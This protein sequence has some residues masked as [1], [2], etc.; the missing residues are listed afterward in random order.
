MKSSKH[1]ESKGPNSLH[2]FE[3]I[4]EANSA[5]LKV[6][7]MHA[8]ISRYER[9]NISLQNDYNIRGQIDLRHHPGLAFK[10]ADMAIIMAINMLK[11]NW[12][13][14]NDYFNFLDLAVLIVN[15][16]SFQ[17]EINTK[18]LLNDF[19]N[20]LTARFDLEL[21]KYN[22]M[23][24]MAVSLE[25]ERL[26]HK[27]QSK[28]IKTNIESLRLSLK[29]IID[30]L[31]ISTAHYQ[32][33]F[34]KAK[35][36]YSVCN[37]VAY[38]ATE[39][40]EVLQEINNQYRVE[41]NFLFEECLIGGVNI[42]KKMQAAAAGEL[43]EY[44]QKFIF[45]DKLISHTKKSNT[46]I[47]PGIYF[48]D[49]PVVRKRQPGPFYY[50][51]TDMAEVNL[52]DV[53]ELN[54]RICQLNNVQEAAG[55]ILNNYDILRSYTL[56]VSCLVS[57]LLPKS[58]SLL[59]NLFHRYNSCPSP[60][61]AAI[62]DKKLNQ[63]EN[64]QLFRNLAKTR[65]YGCSKLNISIYDEGGRREAEYFMSPL[66]HAVEYAPPEVVRI[67]LENN[68][69][70][71]PVD[72][73]K[74]PLHRAMIRGDLAIVKLLLHFGARPNMVTD[75]QRLTPLHD[76]S[77]AECAR[78]LIETVAEQSV[79]NPNLNLSAII[80]AQDC[81]GNTPLLSV[82]QRRVIFHESVA[83]SLERSLV[84]AQQRQALIQVYIDHN[85][86]I[87]VVNKFGH[88]ALHYLLMLKGKERSSQVDLPAAME[89]IRSLV[90]AGANVN[91]TSKEAI[92]NLYESNK[93]QPFPSMTPLL[94]LYDNSDLEAYNR[95]CDKTEEVYINQI[96]ELL[97]NQGALIHVF[98]RRLQ[99]PLSKAIIAGSEIMVQFLLAQGTHPNFRF[100][101]VQPTPL[102]LCMRTTSGEKPSN[103]GIKCMEYLFNAGANPKL[104]LE[105]TLEINLYNKRGKSQFSVN[106]YAMKLILTQEN[107]FSRQALVL[108]MTD[109]EEPIKER[110]LRIWT[111]MNVK[112][113]KVCL[114]MNP[115]EYSHFT[116][117]VSRGP[118]PLAVTLFNSWLGFYRSQEVRAIL[119]ILC[120]CPLWV[121]IPKYL[122]ILFAKHITDNPMQ[123]KH[124]NEW[125]LNGR[126]TLKSINVHKE[127]L[128]P[129]IQR[130]ARLF[131]QDNTSQPLLDQD[132]PGAAFENKM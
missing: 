74:T 33:L 2:A 124:L 59:S 35:S 27:V 67:L 99:T 37:E 53:H 111:S 21:S 5:Y 23:N 75:D 127:S 61:I 122:L 56:K 88:T 91:I 47:F 77:N 32:K 13:K 48:N 104:L 114:E 108:E 129:S 34:D 112:A 125:I 116:S 25:M 6:S 80:N 42:F 65:P 100:S 69:T 96:A 1:A 120:L 101:K 40:V 60:L 28:L 20:L 92:E 132:R 58:H 8:D 19:Q 97:V 117:P 3:I 118:H 82:A 121:H 110:F 43:A 52:W 98:D 45:P 128:T 73:R 54:S 81:S 9:L 90:D 109:N 11:Y 50:N 102:H 26:Q 17:N 39:V 24:D 85:A 106:S 49:A 44:L 22:I 71:N 107:E 113:L 4:E 51:P 131:F 119:T 7:L 70:V 103:S 46:V 29:N 18:S 78:Y 84:Q 10:T 30:L 66:C 63:A 94:T 115:V 72:N 14:A 38:R 79:R 126:K 55:L 130:S 83:H 15:L 89:A 64:L 16:N 31:H 36:L 86:D 95:Y 123:I 87:N 105:K 93:Y 76:A 68:A 57:K 12:A 62:S 41:I